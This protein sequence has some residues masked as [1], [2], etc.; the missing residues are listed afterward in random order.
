MI[1][2]LARVPTLEQL[3]QI[4]HLRYPYVLP[5]F[6]VFAIAAI[7]LIYFKAAVGQARQSNH[8]WIRLVEILFGLGQ[9]RQL[10]SFQK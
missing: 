3:S 8:W 5:I 2:L 1:N 10:I 6:I 7:I 9:E 4:T